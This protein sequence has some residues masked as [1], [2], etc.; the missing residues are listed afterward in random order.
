MGSNPGLSGARAHALFTVMG[1]FLQRFPGQR[2]HLLVKKSAPLLCKQISGPTAHHLFCIL[3]VESTSQVLPTTQ[4]S[5]ITQGGG[6][7]VMG[8]IEGHARVCP[9]Q[10]P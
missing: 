9:P 5:W 8:T 7:L 10:F 6:H 1:W 3:L 2:L 4:G